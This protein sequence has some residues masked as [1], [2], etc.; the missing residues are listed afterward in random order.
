SIGVLR[1]IESSG[2]STG[3][4]LDTTIST[5]LSRFWSG[6]ITYQLHHTMSDTAGINSFP[7]NDWDLRGE[8]ARTS[9]DMRHYLYI[10][11]TLAVGKFFKLGTIVSTHSGQPYTLTTGLDDYNNGRASARP[12]GVARNTLEGTAK[13]P[14]LDLRWSRSF[15]FQRR[16]MEGI[17]LTT[18]IDAFNVLNQVNYD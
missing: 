14:T 2:S 15:S 6:R 18:N 4:A 17:S 10:Y 9:S 1:Q 16:H 13:S 7:A 8:W 11:G 3:Y 12:P 5:N